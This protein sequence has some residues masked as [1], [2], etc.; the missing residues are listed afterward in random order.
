[1]KKE[2]DFSKGKRGQIVK[3]AGKTRITICLDNDVIQAFRELGDDLGL[4]LDLLAACA[5]SAKQWA[6]AKYPYL[7]N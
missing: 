3:S 2:Y 6:A 4:G 7:S 1:M 5:S